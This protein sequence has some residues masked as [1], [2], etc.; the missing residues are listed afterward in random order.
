LVKGLDALY[1]FFVAGSSGE[2]EVTPVE[3]FESGVACGSGTVFAERSQEYLN[4]RFVD[5]PTR[6]FTPLTIRDGDEQVGHCAVLLEERSAHLFDFYCNNEDERVVGALTSYIYRTFPQVE[7]ISFKC[8]D[9]G[10]LSK[11]LRRCGFMVRKNK[12]T[13]LIGGVIPEEVKRES[14]LWHVTIGDTDW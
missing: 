11:M 9:T 14:V 2:L 4:W 1:T 10:P 3:R 13:M 12:E 6:N 5:N 8:I 7:Y